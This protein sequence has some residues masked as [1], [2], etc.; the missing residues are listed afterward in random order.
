[1]K[2]VGRSSHA[3]LE[4]ALL[5]AVGGTVD[6][7][8]ATLGTFARDESNYEVFPLGV[9][10]PSNAEDVV[11]VISVCAEMG[12]AVLPRGV[13]TSLA[14]QACNE[15]VI[16]DTRRLTETEIHPDERTARVQPGVILDGLQRAAAPHGLMFGPDP[17]TQDRCTIGGMLGN[18]ACGPHSLTAGRTS[19]NVIEMGVVTGTGRAL[20]VSTLDRLPDDLGAALDAIAT[21][22]AGEIASRYPNIPRRI[23]GYNLDDLVEGNVAKALVGTEGTCVA[24]TEATLRL[25]DRPRHAAALLLGFR[26]ICEAA[27][28]VPRILAMGP[29]ALE[30][31]HSHLLGS[32]DPKIGTGLLIVECTGDSTAE[33]EEKAREIAKDSTTSLVLSNEDEVTR[34]WS[35][36]S[37]AAWTSGRP[38][39][40]EDAAVAPARLGEYLRGFLE[41]VADRGFECDVYGHFGDGCVHTRIDFDLGSVEGRT[42]FRSLVEDSADLVIAHGGSLSGEHGDGRARSELLVRMFGPVLVEAFGRFKAVW[43]PNGIMNPGIVVNP[44]PLDAHLRPYP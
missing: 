17:A 44:S 4:T 27:D 24:I 15:A 18:N 35:A 8:D 36:R 14:G 22:N 37:E 9:V 39:G 2:T 40:W 42:R 25:V 26:D 41:L 6:F 31:S 43:D 10:T 30:G 28:D 3:A 23:S 29:F 16:V 13:G 38:P 5:G 32:A 11:A 7:S 21:E 33:A 12:V 20:Q 1:M 34:L 19:D